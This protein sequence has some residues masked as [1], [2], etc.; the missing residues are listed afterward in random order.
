MVNKYQNAGNTEQRE[1]QVTVDSRTKFDRMD[2]Q[3]ENEEHGED[4]CHHTDPEGMRP[5]L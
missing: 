3:L 2:K 4:W 1:K 5:N